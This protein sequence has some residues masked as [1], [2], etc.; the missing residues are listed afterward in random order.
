MS[1]VDHAWLRMDR[2]CNWMIITGLMTFDTPLDFELY[3]QRIDDSLVQYRRFRQRLVQN[4]LQLRRPEWED[5]P[6][7]DLN[8]HVV[9]VRL[10]APAD[11]AALQ[12]LVSELM[13]QG[14]DPGRPLWKFYVVENYG[15]GAAVVS[16]LHHCLADGVALVQ[17]LLSMADGV[18]ELVLPGHQSDEMSALQ[19]EPGWLDYALDRLPPSVRQAAHAAEEVARTGLHALGDPYYAVELARKGAD[20]AVAVGRLALRWPDP[21][22]LFKGEMCPDKHAVWSEPLKLSEVKRIGQAYGATIND[23][24]LTAVSGALRRYLLQRQ[25]S[26]SGLSIRGIVPVNLRS[27]ESAEELGNKFGLVFLSL[28]I[29]IADPVRRL[30]AVK[31]CMDGIKDTPEAVAS[32]GILGAL[33]AIPSWLQDI[34][35]GIFDAKGSAVMTNVPGPKQKLTLTGAP[36]DMVMAWVPQ[37][38]RVSLGVSII[39]YNGKVWLG[40]ATD[41]SQVPDPEQI[42]AGF[43]VEFEEFKGLAEGVFEK[44]RAPFRSMLAMLDQAIQTLDEVVEETE[45]ALPVETPALQEP[46]AQKVKPSRGKRRAKPAVLPQPEATVL[47][48]ANEQDLQTTPPAI[49]KTTVKRTRSKKSSP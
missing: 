25:E 32:Y 12:A 36:I 35:I 45:T 10:P 7:F 3:R 24:L 16:R 1:R 4:P 33:G 5:D 39:S 20:L 34:A 49:S 30:R 40:I 11:K 13:G 37:S 28:P 6:D 29:G 47:A 38:G 8:N 18:N 2:P 22:T 27:A 9:R 42:I 46:A 15:Q 26:V 41:Q 23:V 19:G 43:A 44:R 21:Q 17:V 14:L 31:Y 48:Q